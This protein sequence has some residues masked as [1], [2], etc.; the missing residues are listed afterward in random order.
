MNSKELNAAK[1]LYESID[2]DVEQMEND[3]NC[4]Y[5]S[6]NVGRDKQTYVWYFDE[7]SNNIAINVETLQFVDEEF[8]ED[9]FC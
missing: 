1:V 7:I 8:I 6:V 9:N 5:L 4:G 2:H 3:L